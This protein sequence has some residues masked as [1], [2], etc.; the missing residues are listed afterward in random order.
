M[1]G[2]KAPVIV[3]ALLFFGAAA[4]YF[5]SMREAAREAAIQNTLCG[6]HEL[7]LV[8]IFR[9]LADPAK[10]GTADEHEAKLMECAGTGYKL[11]HLR[12]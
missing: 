6:H 10:V 3:G 7:M 11:Q 4:F 9:G 12:R 2:W 1:S 8:M 5:M